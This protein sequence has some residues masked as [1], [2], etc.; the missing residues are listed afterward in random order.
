VSLG[1][2]LADAWRWWSPWKLCHASYARPV[3]EFL[4]RSF[5][6]VTF[7]SFEQ[8]LFPDLSEGAILLLAE[9]RGN[10]RAQFQQRD[11]RHPGALAKL[12]G[13]EKS[14]IPS[15]KPLDSERLLSGK[16]RFIEYLIPERA[17]TL[18]AE[19]RGSDVTMKLGS[20]ADVGI[21]Y[22]SGANGFFHVGPETIK[23]WDIPGSI[24]KPIIRRSRGLRGITLTKRIGA[25]IC[26]RARPLIFFILQ[27][28]SR[29][30]AVCWPT[31]RRR[32]P[33]ALTSAT[34]AAIGPHGIVFPMCIGPTRSCPI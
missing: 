6:R 22:V 19:L 1:F 11:F 13:K 26:N 25:N 17:R 18:Y 30:R 21:G 15:T 20:I 14:G 5:E 24:L 27:I 34:N 3:L 4:G 7:L 8:P 2:V 16:E 23:K 12:V 32:K 33:K 28:I 10:H 9:N 31:L 29:S